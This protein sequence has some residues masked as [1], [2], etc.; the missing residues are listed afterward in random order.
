MR[1]LKIACFLFASVILSVKASDNKPPI[2]IEDPS[3]HKKYN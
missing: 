1:I 3:V 2:I